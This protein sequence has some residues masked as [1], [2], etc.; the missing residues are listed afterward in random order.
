MIDEYKDM[1]EEEILDCLLNK[2]IGDEEA[3]ELIERERSELPYL[4]QRKSKQTAMQHV[5]ALV[6]H[7]KTW[8]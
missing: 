7:L 3:I 8:H 2:Y 4:R 6:G 1:I 5:L